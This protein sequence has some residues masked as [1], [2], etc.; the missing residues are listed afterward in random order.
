MIISASRRTDIPGLY[1]EWMLRRLRA[2]FCMVRHPFRPASARRVPLTPADVDAIVF[3][4]K[5]PASMIPSL[6]EI[7]GLGFQ[8]HFLFTI[9]GYPAAVEPELPPLEQRIDTFRRL[10]DR[11]GPDGVVWRYDPIILSSRFDA[12][13]HA[14]TF[15]ELAC[16]LHGRTSRVI[17][18]L[19]DFYRKTARRLGALEAATGDSFARDP[20]AVPRLAELIGRM[21]EVCDAEGIE[22]QSCCEDERLE[23]LGVRPGK[24]IDDEL[25]L[26]LHG[27]RVPERKDPGQRPGC[28]CV[29]SVD[30]GAA[31]TCTH[32]CEYCYATVSADAARRRRSA[33]DPGS[34]FLAG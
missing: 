4:T 27:T 9:T 25:I 28:R 19:V 21:R 5:N 23:R 1:A 32:G 31:D 33:H 17:V 29:A 18:S 30:I 12:E 10:A 34:P 14:R 11:I 24:C 16:A 20:F 6:H 22:M 2:G 26:R 8:F 3:W 7:S 13:Y 15:A